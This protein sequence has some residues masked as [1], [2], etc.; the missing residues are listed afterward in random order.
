M[1][2]TEPNNDPR[3]KGIILGGGEMMAYLGIAPQVNEGFV[4]PRNLQ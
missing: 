1:K 4:S 2:I 3:K